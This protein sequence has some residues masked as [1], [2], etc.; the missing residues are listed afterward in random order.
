M[1]NDPSHVSAVVMATQS[2]RM[3][4]GKISDACSGGVGFHHVPADIPHRNTAEC[5][6]PDETLAPTDLL[7]DPEGEEDHTERFG[8]TIEA[9][10]EEL[11]RSTGNSKTLKDTGR[12]VGND[13]DTSE[14]LQKHESHTDT[15]AVTHAL[16]EKLLELLLLTHLVRTALLNLRTN[17]AHLPANILMLRRKTSNLSENLL[18][19]LKVITTCQPAR[20]LRTPKHTE[21]KA[22]TRKKLHRQRD[23]PLCLCVNVDGA[24]SSVVDPEAKHTAALRG[25][26]EDTHET[27]SDGRRGSFADVYWDGEGG[28]SEAETGDGSAAVDHVEVAV[29]G[30]HEGAAEEED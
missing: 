29:C 3:S 24:V 23:N 17:I 8:D 10:G 1:M 16:L 28:S 9:S 25:D 11:Q 21:R 22:Q 5:S 4:R 15:H 19:R 20:R 26:L 18:R 12:V 7:N 6:T 14:T 2:M 13:V 27:A 30:G